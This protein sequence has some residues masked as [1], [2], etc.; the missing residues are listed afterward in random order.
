MR[1]CAVY[2][3]QANY[4]EED[5]LSW[6]DWVGS[7]PPHAPCAAN[8]CTLEALSVGHTGPALTLAHSSGIR[9]WL[10]SSAAVREGPEG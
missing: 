9:G 3:W 4:E 10:E 8:G 2:G 7:K 1:S 5:L 6:R